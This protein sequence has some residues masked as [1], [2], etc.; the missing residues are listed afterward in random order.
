MYKKK[1]SS[2][3]IRLISEVPAFLYC[4]QQ[5]VSLHVW[6]QMNPFWTGGQQGKSH[7]L[8]ANGNSKTQPIFVSLIALLFLK[9][10]YR[11]GSEE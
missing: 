6:R 8:L 1:K 7:T 4:I 2:R 5:S 9:N 11:T 10:P 3:L